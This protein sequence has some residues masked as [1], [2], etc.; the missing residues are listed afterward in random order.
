MGTLSPIVVV[1]PFRQVPVGLDELFSSAYCLY[2]IERTE[3]WTFV[4]PH[5]SNRKD[6]KLVMER[7]IKWG[8]GKPTLVMEE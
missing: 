6:E 1:P 3:S 4:A 5:S 2:R 8:S 7:K